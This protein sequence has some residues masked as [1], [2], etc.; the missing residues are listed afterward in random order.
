MVTFVKQE[1]M[2][3]DGTPIAIGLTDGDMVFLGSPQA[4]AKL[5]NP[6]QAVSD[7]PDD[8]EKT[9]A[10]VRKLT[11]ALNRDA[12]YRLHRSDRHGHLERYAEQSRL[13]R[14]DTPRTFFELDNM[15]MRPEQ[16]YE[17][18]VEEAG[19][20]L[21]AQESREL[22]GR[23]AAA[24]RASEAKRNALLEQRLGELGIAP[25][26]ETITLSRVQLS[27]LMRQ[28]AEIDRS[29]SGRRGRP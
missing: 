19:H 11:A 7:E 6:R 2:S 20:L 10:A 16:V 18:A 13:S 14:D 26:A 17:R 3:I 8:V 25:D 22:E 23:W 5:E 29:S 9:Q 15:D 21:G 4:L 28:A 27:D 1:T 12:G 24:G